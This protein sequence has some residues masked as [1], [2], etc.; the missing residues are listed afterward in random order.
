M[1]LVNGLTA[2]V[3]PESVASTF[4]LAVAAATALHNSLQV[5]K[6]TKAHLLW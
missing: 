4:H 3:N 1:R 2:L 6:D 5:S